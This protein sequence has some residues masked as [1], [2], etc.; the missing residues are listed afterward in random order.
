MP[1]L[2]DNENS[3][4]GRPV[5]C[6]NPDTEALQVSEIA[7]TRTDML[8]LEKVHTVMDQQGF[9]YNCDWIIAGNHYLARFERRG[10]HSTDDTYSHGR[11]RTVAEATFNAYRD[12]VNDLMAQEG[13]E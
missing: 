13:R 12:A 7:I 11:G 8:D 5:S 2:A 3:V 1:S 9:T 10:D 6:F 4:K